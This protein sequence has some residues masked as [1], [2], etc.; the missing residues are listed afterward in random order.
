MSLKAVLETLDGIEEAVA[1]LY[2]EK[3]GKYLLDVEPV[4]GFTLENSDGLRKTLQKTR[5]QLSKAEAKLDT[6]KGVDPDSAREALSKMEE[7]ASWDPEKKI[8]EGMRAREQQLLEKHSKELKAK[9][10]RISTLTNQ[11][12]DVLVTQT[13]TK[14]IA[15][16]KGVVDLVLPHVKSQIQMRLDGSGKY[17]TDVIDPKDKTVRLS[18]KSGSTDPMRI[19]E[20][21]EELQKSPVFARAFEGSGASGSGSTGQNQGQTSSRGFLLSKEDLKNPVKYR[22][23]K[24]AAEKAGSTLQMAE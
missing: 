15:D 17:V 19:D 13:A 2:V 16:R 6:F 14:A 23:A 18:P 7:L 11:L 10:E 4:G 5:D 9:D 24:E 22:A 21:I 1:S 12:E 8:Q 3:D 20:L